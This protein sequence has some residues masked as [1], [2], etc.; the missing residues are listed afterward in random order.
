MGDT[1]AQP[2][3]SSRQP[4]LTW[5]ETAIRLGLALFFLYLFNFYCLF[6]YFITFI[7]FFRHIHSL[8]EFKSHLLAIRFNNNI[9][10]KNYAK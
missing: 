1:G 7:F 5:N 3:G 6:D 9:I 8:T 4:F 10:L 2:E